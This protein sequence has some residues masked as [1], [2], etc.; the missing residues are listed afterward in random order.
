MCRQKF[1]VAFGGEKKMT[2]TEKGEFFLNFRWKNTTWNF[3]K[4][5]VAPVFLAD[6][7]HYIFERWLGRLPWFEY[8]KKKIK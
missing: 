7:M 4:E 6:I 3:K 2:K 5:I 8:T 1:V